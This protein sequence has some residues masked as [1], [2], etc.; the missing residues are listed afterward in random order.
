MKA[1]FNI[2]FI[3]LSSVL[4]IWLGFFAFDVPTMIVY[5]QKS[6]YWFLTISLFLW[7]DTLIDAFMGLENQRV[8]SIYSFVTSKISVF[9]KQHWIAMVLSLILMTI[10]TI[11]CK[12][13]F[14]VLADETNL[15][16]ISQSLYESKETHLTISSFDYPFSQKDILQDK[17]EKRPA[18][19]PYLLDLIHTLTGY[20]AENVFVFNFIIGFLS[21]FLVYYLIYIIW[22]KYWGLLGAI[23][24]VSYPLFIMYVNSAGFEVFNML[25]SLIF[26]LCL[27]YYI[28]N[29]IAITAEVLLFFVPLISQSRYESILSFFVAVPVILYLLPKQE[30]SRLSNKIN[31][32][33]LLFITPVWLRLTTNNAYSWQVDNLQE[34]FGFNWFIINLKKALKF[35]FSGNTVYGI[36]P[37]ISFLAVIGFV[38]FVYNNFLKENLS[39]EKEQRSNFKIYSFFVFVFYLLHAVVRFFYSWIDLTNPIISRLGIVF[40]PLFIFMSIYFL[41]SFVNKFQVNK[42]IF[43]LI[44]LTIFLFYLPDAVKMTNFAFKN[45]ELL[46]DMKTTVDYLE[47]NFPNKRE[48]IVIRERPNLLT[49]LGYNAV[50]FDNYNSDILKPIIN[51]YY[52]EKYCLFFIVVQIIDLKTNLPLE[53][54]KIPIGAEQKVVY[55]KFLMQDH[56]L[57]ISRYIPNNSVLGK[58]AEL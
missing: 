3:I 35:Y 42:Y 55:E 15:V 52:D 58:E 4:S 13:Y 51:N 24:L 17:I 39:V 43:G 22:G 49:P 2:F 53:G 28:K 26:F 31:C 36:I 54:Y 46:L 33:P 6:V 47:T 25:C 50:G 23:S 10:G 30:Y 29:P 34:G 16:S 20:R 5:Y 18:F 14:R 21:L 7:L 56:L 48:Y 32:F 38:I 11:S 40:L 41:F 9:F 27:F 57:R 19:F 1:K 45:Y 37:I 8:K 12:P 44:Y